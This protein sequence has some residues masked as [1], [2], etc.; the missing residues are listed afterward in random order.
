MAGEFPLGCRRG[1]GEADG[2]A[3]G[4]P[5]EGAVA[6]GEA[7]DRVAERGDP[8]HG[9]LRESV[10]ADQVEEVA[11]GGALVGDRPEVAGVP[12]DLLQA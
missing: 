6:L 12:P 1:A 3:V 8:D 11:A 7:D 5:S 9:S 4:A 10:V 2:D